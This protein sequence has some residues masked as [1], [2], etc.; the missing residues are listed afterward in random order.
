MKA[1]LRYRHQD[2]LK[3][4]YLRSKLQYLQFR[5]F[6][7]LSNNCWGGIVYDDIGIQYGSPFV[8]MF[9]YADCYLKMLENLDHHLSVDLEFTNASSYQDQPPAYPVG[10]LRDAEIHFI[11]YKTKEE[12][13]ESWNRRKSRINPDRL[14]LVLSERDG[15]SQTHIERFDALPHGKKVLFAT[16]PYKLKNTKVITSKIWNKVVPPADQMAGVSYVNL[17]LISY[18]NNL[19]ENVIPDNFV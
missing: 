2:W 4:R 10:M 5:D 17:D 15:C 19:P 13:V 12:A 9:M 16:R 18:L 8:N 3:R 6:S 14:M 7:I 11:H 1:F